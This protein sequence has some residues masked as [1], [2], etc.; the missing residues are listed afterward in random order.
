LKTFSASAFFYLGSA[1]IVFPYEPVASLLVKDISMGSG[2]G[3]S[4][5]SEFAYTFPSLSY[6]L[7]SCIEGSS[8]YLS[9]S[10]IFPFIFNLKTF[11]ATTFFLSTGIVD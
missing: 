7:A 11:S 8:F 9:N 6:S 1:G 2:F 3:F 5:Y 10:G 4:S